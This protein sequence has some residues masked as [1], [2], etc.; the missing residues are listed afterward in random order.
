MALGLRGMSGPAGAQDLNPIKDRRQ[1]GT[2]GFV[3]GGPGQELGKVVGRVLRMPQATSTGANGGRFR[4]IKGALE[5]VE[6]KMIAF[7]AAPSSS[8]V[9]VRRPSP[10]LLSGMPKRPR[11]PEVAGSGGSGTGPLANTGAAQE[12]LWGGSASSS[13]T[14]GEAECFRRT[15]KDSRA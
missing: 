1:G 6:V 4:C 2:Q 3:A 10:C 5:I 8:R 9:M 14:T 13:Q 7:D 15:R 12:S 11:P